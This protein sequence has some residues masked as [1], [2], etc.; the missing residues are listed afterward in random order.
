[1]KSTSPELK[2]ALRFVESILSLEEQSPITIDF[3]KKQLTNNID[4]PASDSPAL[5]PDP[6]TLVQVMADLIEKCQ[7]SETE[8][9]EQ[10]G[11]FF[12]LR[13]EFEKER[14]I[15]FASIQEA[16][17]SNR[18]KQLLEIALEESQKEIET[19]RQTIA[20]QLCEFE[21]ERRRILSLFL[22]VAH[23][24]AQTPVQTQDQE[25][26]YEQKRALTVQGLE[27]DMQEDW[28]N[29]EDTEEQNSEEQQQQQAVGYILLE[30]I[31]NNYST[32][33]LEPVLFKASPLPP[34]EENLYSFY[35]H[36]KILFLAF[37]TIF[38]LVSITLLLNCGST[39]RTP[40]SIVREARVL[41]QDLTFLVK[42]VG[43]SFTRGNQQ[44]E[45]L[46][47]VRTW[48]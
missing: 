23:A 15:G 33:V 27:E 34:Q 3:I 7:Q 8:L 47:L 9:L 13:T 46:R 20:Q 12:E 43:G 6:S 21:E 36:L 37:T 35:P 11:V 22:Q 17:L 32:P 26:T 5:T 19:L 48:S 29:A 42:A 30:T 16:A 14:E 45:A 28:M 2:R 10:Q 41:V 31:N 38:V 4:A 18:E 40:D 1:M 39:A 25:M 44:Q 24:R